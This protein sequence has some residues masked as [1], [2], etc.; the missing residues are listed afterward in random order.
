MRDGWGRGRAGLELDRHAVARLVRAAMPGAAVTAAA[1]LSGGLAN[2]NLRLVLDGDPGQALLRIYQ[3]DPA[4]AEK[5]ATLHRL[6]AGRVPA[7]R[8][9]APPATDAESGLRF[10]ILE[11][12][13]GEPLERVLPGLHPAGLRVLGRS[14]GRTLAAVHAFAFPAAGFLDGQLRVVHPV[15]GGRD[16]LLGFLRRC[17]VDGIGG[18]RLGPADTAAVLAFAGPAG[19]RLAAWEARPCL[20]HADFNGSNLLAAGDTVTAVLDWEFA[21]AGWPAFDFGNLLRPPAGRLEGFADAAADGYRAAGGALP[22]DWRRLAMIADLYAWA[23]FLARP[24]AT[25]GLVRDAVAM[26]RSIVAEAA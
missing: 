21:F 16:G 5:E 4:Q 7:P 19:D 20:V 25:D 1:P 18:D 22:D 2:T 12:M 10:A 9:L 8:F 15:A 6:V 26:V 13:P 14:V 3:R 24:D 17:L 11:W 23:D